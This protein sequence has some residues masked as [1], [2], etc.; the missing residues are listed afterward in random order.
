MR[1]QEKAI[2]EAIKAIFES[3]ESNPKA[4][5][6]YSFPVDQRFLTNADM[7]ETVQLAAAVL[8]G[9]LDKDFTSDR[10]KAWIRRGYFKP[11]QADPDLRNNLYCAIDVVRL[12]SIQ[13]AT[14]FCFELDVAAKIAEGV[15][16][17]YTG[18]GFEHSGKV[19]TDRPIFVHMQRSAD[20]LQATEYV[21]TL[22]DLEKRPRDLAW[23][24]HNTKAAIVCM[25]DW[26]RIVEVAV[27]SARAT[28][29]QRVEALRPRIVREL[30]RQRRAEGTKA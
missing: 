13:H 21:I 10:L 15:V 7:V 16:H 24:I 9:P 12:V 3:L 19:P 23:R 27:L 17:L 5:A 29:L 20:N 6:Q 22:P 25:I 8:G 14:N 2:F 1:R 26:A 18:P 4:A 30:A 28:W 11:W